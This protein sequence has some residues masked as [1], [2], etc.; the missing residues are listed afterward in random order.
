[1]GKL[2]KQVFLAIALWVFIAAA[3]PGTV[4]AISLEFY[5]ATQTITQGGQADVAVWLRELNGNQIGTFDMSVSF[6]PTVLGLA[7]DPVAFGVGL[8]APNDSV[9]AIVQGAGFIE[10]TETSLLFDLSG[11]P[12]DELLLF[13]LS[14]IGINQ[15]LSSLLF[16]AVTLGDA[17]GDPLS[18]DYLSATVTVEPRQNI[19]PEPGTLLLLGVGLAGLACLRRRSVARKE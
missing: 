9:Q 12:S 17:N 18:A 1:M 14:F 16:D 19:V 4:S 11:Q 3:V 5:P 8:G 15:G 7:A 6:D 13:T 10:V 2:R